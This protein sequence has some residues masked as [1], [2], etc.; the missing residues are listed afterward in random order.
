MY[1]GVFQLSCC[2]RKLSVLF[3][4]KEK[5]RYENQK[6]TRPQEETTD[7]VDGVKQRLNCFIKV[8]STNSFVNTDLCLDILTRWEYRIL[9]KVKCWLIFSRRLISRATDEIRTLKHRSLWLHYDC[10]ANGSLLQFIRRKGIN[11]YES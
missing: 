7:H 2:D 1:S 8:I 3:N 4:R 9:I 11:G 10:H 6:L 5:A